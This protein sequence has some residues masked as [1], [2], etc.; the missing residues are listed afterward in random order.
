MLPR[1]FESRA[2]LELWACSACGHVEF[3]L[4]ER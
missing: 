3:F 2:R 1:I 4:P